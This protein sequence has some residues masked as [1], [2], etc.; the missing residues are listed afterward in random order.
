MKALLIGHCVPMK[1]ITMALLPFRSASAQVL[2]AESLRAKRSIF[3]PSCVVGLSAR[4]AGAASSATAA[5][6]V[7]S[8]GEQR[9]VSRMG[10]L[11]TGAVQVATNDQGLCEARTCTYF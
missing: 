7:S 8:R 6:S 11:G 9:A 10:F 2:P 1:T 4:E 3:L 5:A